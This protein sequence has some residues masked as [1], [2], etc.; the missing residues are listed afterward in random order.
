MH[1]HF[2][3][4][5]TIVVS[6]NGDLSTGNQ[7]ASLSM[8]LATLLPCDSMNK[9]LGS[10]HPG[11]FLE[12]VSVRCQSTPNVKVQLHTTVWRYTQR[13]KNVQLQL[14]LESGYFA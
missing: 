6:K 8:V 12:C 7:E 13:D 1:L 5:S 3:V 9:E 10:K 14:H 2:T 11:V 4:L